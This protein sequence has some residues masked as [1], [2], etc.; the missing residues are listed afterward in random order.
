[1]SQSI[2]LS[3]LIDNK[4]DW[5]PDSWFDLPKLEYIGLSKNNLKKFPGSSFV[6][7]KSLIY[8]G[9]DANEILSLSVSNLKPF[10]GNDS[11]L[12]HLNVSNNAIYSIST[13]AFS[14][15]IHL[16]VLELQGNNISSIGAKVFHEIPELLHLILMQQQAPYKTTTVMYNAF[17][18][19]PN[20]QDLWL[21]GNS[22]THFPHPAL[23]QE[24]FPFLRYLSQEI[25]HKPFEKITSLQRL[26]LHRNSI[27]NIQEDDLWLLSSLQQLYFSQNQLSNATVHPDA[28]RN[29]TSLTTLHLDFNNFHYVPLS[30]Q[31]KSHLPQVQNLVLNSNKI[32]FIVEG[33][34]SE[35]DTLN[36]LEIISN[37]IVAIENGAFPVTIN[38][39]YLQNNR[40]NF[41]HENQF[42]NL[43]QLSYLN[44]DN[45]FI[46]VVP[47]TSFHGLSSLTTLSLNFNKICRI[48]KVIF[49]DLTSLQTLY[50]SQNDIAF[51]ED[52][53][54]S[55]LPVLNRLDLNNNQ[56]TTLPVD[57]D[58]HNKRIDRLDLRNNRIT[59]IR[60]GTFIN[61]TCSGNCE[62]FLRYWD[63]SG[64]RVSVIES[65]AFQNVQGSRSCILRFTNNVLKHIESLAFDDVNVCQIEMNGM[66]LTTLVS[67]TFRN[68]AVSKDL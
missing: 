63:F 51:I 57:G 17:K 46:D 7:C 9:I 5:I 65:G 29:L 23:S 1:M 60:K 36:R 38:T 14:G 35:L 55:N 19:L 52:G 13:G 62:Q 56:L 41:K 59:S 58:F 40:F 39:L 10:Y 24:S 6:N 31:G 26:F 50:L 3:I 54:L 15:L 2:Y 12:V 48:L 25:V 47:N 43:S 11:Q 44:L 45:N 53:A 32:T 68:V 18:N 16:K 49:K 64:N 67:E 61:T 66:Q 8:L 20:L 28:F 33:T 42:T 30:V 34:F 37:Q 4:I 27:T 22:L 21:S